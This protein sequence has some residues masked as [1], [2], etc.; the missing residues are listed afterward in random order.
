MRVAGEDVRAPARHRGAHARRLAAERAS[1]LRSRGHL[2][3]AASSAAD[4]A[5]PRRSSW[6]RRPPVDSAAR[7]SCRSCSSTPAAQTYAL[8]V[9]RLLGK[10]EIVLKSL[11]AL[12]GD[13]PCAAGATLHRRSRRA[14]P[15][16]PAGG[17]ARVWRGAPAPQ[18]AR[19]SAAP[20]SRRQPRPRAAAD[21]ARR[22]LRRRPRV[23]A[24]RARGARLRGRRRARRRR[25]ARARRPRP[26]RLRP[27][28]DR[29]HDAATSTA[30]S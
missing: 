27:R 13:V 29:R 19:P 10:R 7:A 23:A 24:A 21:P 12:L 17:A 3:S 9:E 5:R 2:S 30:T 6:R 28:L 11:G 20:P 14:H 1:R 25:G 8:V 4:L 26:A 18:P 16:R 22:G 15:R